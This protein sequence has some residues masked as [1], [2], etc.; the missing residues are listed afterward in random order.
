MWARRTKESLPK[1]LISDMILVERHDEAN[2]WMAWPK[3]IEFEVGV[4]ADWV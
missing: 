1:V 3:R 2:L 4:G